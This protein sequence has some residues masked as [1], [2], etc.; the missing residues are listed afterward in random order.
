MILPQ[1][2]P[3]IEAGEIASLPSYRFYM[4]L[5]ALNPEEP[6]SGTTVPVSIALNGIKEKE[7]VE[8]SRKLYAREWREVSSQPVVK[9]DKASNK[10][11]R[12]AVK[13]GAI[14]P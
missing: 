10:P 3:Y 5:G 14:L 2:R 9:S 12:R 8:S 7:V 4:R 11:S 6:F 1:F 13:K